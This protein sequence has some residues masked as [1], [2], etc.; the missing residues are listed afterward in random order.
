M[1]SFV[2]GKSPNIPIDLANFSGKSIE[3]AAPSLSA[4][5]ETAAGGGAFGTSVFFPSDAVG[6][7]MAM[8]RLGDGI[9]SKRPASQ[10][11]DGY[12]PLLPALLPPS[13][14]SFPPKVFL[15]R[16]PLQN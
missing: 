16:V 3:G 5:L 14:F 4:L 2:F 9:R 6:A 13:P 1:P 7:D 8:I 15:L 11:R 10:S 12:T